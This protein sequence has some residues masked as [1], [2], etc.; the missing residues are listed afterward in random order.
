MSGISNLDE[1]LEALLWFSPPRSAGHQAIP[2]MTR[3]LRRLG[4]PQDAYRWVHVAGTSGKTSTAYHIRA[5]LEASGRRTGLTVSP[6]VVAV[7][8][9]VQVGGAPLADD[10]F[11]AHLNEFLP[12][13]RSLGEE[14]T[15]FEL[16]VAL[17]LWTFAREAVDYAVVEVGIGGTRDATNV[18][19]RPDK[20]A[21]VGP[22]G[23]DHTEVLGRTVREIAAQKAGIIGPGNTA[24]VLR[25][26]PDVTAIITD[27][28]AAMAG[29][30]ILVDP[31]E[32]STFRERNAAVA[33]TAVAHLAERDGFRSIEPIRLDQPPARF[34]ILPVNGRRVVLDGAHN[35]QKMAGLVGALRAAGIERAAVLCTLMQAPEHKLEETLAVIAPIVSHLIVT[36]YAL[37]SGRKSKT[38]F[39]SAEVAAMARRLGVDVEVAAD[40]GDGVRRLLARSER[41]LVV[42]GSLYLASLVRPLLLR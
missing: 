28:V 30:A 12:L 18:L 39:Q 36:D 25:Q 15:Y 34:E 21:V 37:G 29:T 27:R 31:D 13:A 35:P 10:R 24:V 16:G 26:D 8:E 17:A 42:T 40:V 7:N 33:R 38:S 3:L 22:V 41:D 11:L 6:H 23:L 32:P 5:M 1:A 14:L 19:Q 20:L 4:D 2:T 9:R